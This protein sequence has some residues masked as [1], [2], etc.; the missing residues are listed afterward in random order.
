[1]SAEQ[2]WD[3]IVSLVRESPDAPDAEWEL[4][5]KETS[6]RRQ[7]I[8]E[9]VYDQPAKQ[10][11]RNGLEILKVQK[12]LSLK[13]DNAVEKLTA[14]REANDLEK[15]REASRDVKDARRETC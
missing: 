2:V 4:S 13:I 1:M 5:G 9:S 14:A 15:I 3:S 8:G 6:L 12:D 11:V 10:F 7:L